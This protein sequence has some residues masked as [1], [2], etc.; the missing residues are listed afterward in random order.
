[1]VQ[2]PSPLARLIGLTVAVELQE[3]KAVAL[4]FLFNFVLLGSYYILRPVRD[5]MMQQR[6]W[7]AGFVALALSLP[8][9]AQIAGSDHFATSGGPVDIVPIHHASMLHFEPRR[10]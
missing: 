6:I 5:T 8:A 1:M 9:G 2:K 7:A 10:S 3:V 4:A